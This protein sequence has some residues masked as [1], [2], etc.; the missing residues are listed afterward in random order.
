MCLI[1]KSQTLFSLT[2]CTFSMSLGKRRKK[3]FPVQWKVLRGGR[4]N[5]LVDR[6]PSLL[7]SAG[8]RTLSKLGNPSLEQLSLLSLDETVE[9]YFLKCKTFFFFSW[10][11]CM[12]ADRFHTSTPRIF[13]L[14]ERGKLHV[15]HAHGARKDKFWLIYQGKSC[16]LRRCI[17]RHS[18]TIWTQ[19][20][21][22]NSLLVI[23]DVPQ[24]FPKC[25]CLHPR[26]L[27]SMK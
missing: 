8:T 9:N 25:T 11:V 20:V 7:L 19:S 16:N 24:A 4:F 15:H 1:N 6:C 18:A 26:A 21:T 23:E 3:A 22:L 14:L 13:A 27:K 5:L 12:R 17:L 10:Q 2:S